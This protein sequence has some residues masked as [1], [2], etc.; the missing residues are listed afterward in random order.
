[1]AYELLSHLSKGLFERCD[2]VREPGDHSGG[3]LEIQ[4][5]TTELGTWDLKKT[6]HRDGTL[7]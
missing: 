1:M 6:D 5:W 2:A 4:I 3:G 7:K